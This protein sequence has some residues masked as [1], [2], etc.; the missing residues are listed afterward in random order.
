MA[1]HS[2]HLLLEI[3]VSILNLFNL[4]PFLFLRDKSKPVSVCAVLFY[5]ATC[6]DHIQNQD[7][8]GEMVNGQNESAE[9]MSMIGDGSSKNTQT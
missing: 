4:L 1:K 5:M 9:K 8:R 7:I 2:P 6:L 3:T